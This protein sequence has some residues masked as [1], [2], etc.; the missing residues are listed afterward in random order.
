M[1]AVIYFSFL[2][3]LFPWWEVLVELIRHKNTCR[4]PELALNND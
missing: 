1:T 3:Y 2:G 4:Q